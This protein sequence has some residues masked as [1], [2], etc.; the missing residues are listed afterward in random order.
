M[1]TKYGMFLEHT[2]LRP[3]VP[4]L[5]SKTSSDGGAKQQDP[6]AGPKDREHGLNMKAPVAKTGKVG[7]H[8]LGTREPNH[9]HCDGRH[10]IPRVA[11]I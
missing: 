2:Y 8:V 4:E 9:S 11:G 6:E 3:G 7:G 10:S 1:T 5:G